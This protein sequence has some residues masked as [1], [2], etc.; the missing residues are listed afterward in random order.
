MSSSQTLTALGD[1]HVGPFLSV[2][3]AE[4]VEVATRQSPHLCGDFGEALKWA[5]SHLENPAQTKDWPW[6]MRE[7]GRVLSPAYL[8]SY[9]STFAGR[10]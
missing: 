7:D 9:A 8:R 6:V 1:E 10:P 2:W 3:A 4:P 5:S